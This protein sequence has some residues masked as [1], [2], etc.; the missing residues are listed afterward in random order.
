MVKELFIDAYDEYGAMILEFM[1]DVAIRVL[2]FDY[3]EFEV[4]TRH[5]PSEQALL[6]AFW[7]ISECARE[8]RIYPRLRFT[9]PPPH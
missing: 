6:S 9:E 1:D 7:Q 8:R 3:N 4:M 2:A 5:C